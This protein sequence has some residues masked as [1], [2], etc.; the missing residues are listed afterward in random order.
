MK[1]FSLTLIL[2]LGLAHNAHC[3]NTV[4]NSAISLTDNIEIASDQVEVT[5]VWGRVMAEHKNLVIYMDIINNSDS[6]LNLVGVNAPQHTNQAKIHKIVA[7]AAKANIGKTEVSIAPATVELDSLTIP[8]HSKVRLAPSNM[9]TE[10]HGAGFI[11]LTDVSDID[12]INNGA[13]LKGIQLVF[14]ESPPKDIEV[15]IKN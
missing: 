14:K 12:K 13:L 3:Q 8:A 7:S 11:I 1:N 6:P 2:A 4:K 5:S 9:T 15:E 10:E